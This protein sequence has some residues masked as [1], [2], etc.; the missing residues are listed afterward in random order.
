M[1]VLALAKA[2]LGPK[3]EKNGVELVLYVRC[4]RS[5]RQRRR[6]LQWLG[7]NKELSVLLAN[8]ACDSHC[9]C[10]LSP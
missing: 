5:L 6:R 9:C 3:E 4:F 8:M 1:T 10:L 2:P 7:W